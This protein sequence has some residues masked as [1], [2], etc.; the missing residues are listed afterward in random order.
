MSSS[1]GIAAAVVIVGCRRL[2]NGVASVLVS[3]V[4]MARKTPPLMIC[5]TRGLV[6]GREGLEGW[7][8]MG[9]GDHL[10]L[11]GLNT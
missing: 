4:V 7:W 6:T 10:E 2:S 3:W 8:W 5:V 11:A 1:I 9:M